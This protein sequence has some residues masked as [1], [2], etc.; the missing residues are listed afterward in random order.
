MLVHFIA[1]RKHHNLKRRHFR[2]SVCISIDFQSAI[3]SGQMLSSKM[4]FFAV[5]LVYTLLSSD[6]SPLQLISLDGSC[7]S[8][9][10][11]GNYVSSQSISK[12]GNMCP[13][14]ALI[15]CTSD[16]DSSSIINLLFD[17]SFVSNSKGQIIFYT[18]FFYF[19]PS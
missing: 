9:S 10:H 17:T 19:I 11:I 7:R 5:F 18:L 12:T 14:S 13:V 16:S 3:E 6:A 4:K 8:A 1:C 2:P 15:D